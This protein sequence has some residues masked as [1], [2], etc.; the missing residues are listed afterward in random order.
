[1][2]VSAVSGIHGGLGLYPPFVRGDYCTL[3]GTG[4][5]QTVEGKCFACLGALQ[6]N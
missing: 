2:V 3:K 6:D 5:M 1:M 4:I